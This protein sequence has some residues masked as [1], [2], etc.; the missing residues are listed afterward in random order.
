[1]FGG[2]QTML[3]PRRNG[4]FSPRDALFD[5]MIELPQEV[6]LLGIFLGSRTQPCDVPMQGL[7]VFLLKRQIMFVSRVDKAPLVAPDSRNARH[8]FLNLS[9]HLLRA[10]DPSRARLKLI[11]EIVGYRCGDNQR[12]DAN[13]ESSRRQPVKRPH[14]SSLMPD[15]RQQTAPQHNKPHRRINGHPTIVPQ[16]DIENQ[17]QHMAGQRENANPHQRRAQPSKN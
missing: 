13:H 6:L 3:A 10:A 12:K 5:Q 15:Q 7:L 4:L 8:D 9:K 2:R 1:M 11:G 14:K 16:T 17:S